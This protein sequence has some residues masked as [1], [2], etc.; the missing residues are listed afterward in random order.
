M[1]DV[2]TYSD[3]I[4]RRLE[5]WWQKPRNYRHPATYTD[6]LHQLRERNTFRDR[7]DAEERWRCCAHWQ[8]SLSNKWN[9]RE[10]AL[11][12]G[13]RV[14]ELYWYG[15][16][17]RQA[18]FETL[19]DHYVI[20]QSFGSGR[21]QVFVFGDGREIVWG[22]EI[23]VDA[24]HRRLGGTARSF[25]RGR[26]L[27]EEFVGR[28]SGTSEMPLECKLF[29]F[30][31]Q[32][33]AIEVFRRSHRRIAPESYVDGL[34]LIEH[35]CYSAAWE[36]FEDRFFTADYVR[37]SYGNVPSSEP[38]SPPGFLQELIAAGRKLGSAYGTHARI[39]FLVGEKGVFFNEFGT[40]PSAAALTPFADEYLGLLWQETS[41]DET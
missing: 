5:V 36:P 30:G 33:G 11:R 22:R 25:G 7:F 32:V 19:P 35:R 23:G 21:Q 39:D 20:R 4:A 17:I 31:D 12:H 24:M 15:R 41:P 28:R 27:V 10:F 14:P 26:I 16:D 3:R 6:F 29:M 9:A 13:C 8:R 37:K 40:T 2:P 1:S 18:P 34:G 38:S